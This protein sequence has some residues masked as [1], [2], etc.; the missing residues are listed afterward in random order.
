MWKSNSFVK[1]SEDFITKIKDIHINKTDRLVSFDITC[2][3][4]N[5][6]IVESLTIVRNK[7]ERDETL[8]EW[9][10]LS[11]KAIKWE[12]CL[13]TIYFQVKDEFYQQSEGMAMGSPLSPILSN[14]YMEHFKQTAIASTEHKLSLWLRCVNDIFSIWL[15]GDCELVKFIKHF[16]T[17]RPSITFTIEKEN[18][19][20]LPFLDI[21]IDRN[22]DKITTTVYRKPT[23]TGQYLHYIS[24]H[25]KNTEQVIVNSVQNRSTVIC[26]NED[27]LLKE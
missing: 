10:P 14:K 23:H 17:Q 26:S 21:L 6:P 15:H 19:G 18:I 7:L 24:N 22:N 1:N 5:V 8:P 16:N 27:D 4:I 9:S 11:V 2:L 25:P 13:K 20:K 12:L 3:F